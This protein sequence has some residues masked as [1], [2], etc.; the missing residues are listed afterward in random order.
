MKFRVVFCIH[1][2][3]TMRIACHTYPRTRYVRNMV[4]AR[5]STS[6]TNMM[7]SLV[8]GRAIV[9]ESS[10]MSNETLLLHL[11]HMAPMRKTSILLPSPFGASGSLK[12]NLLC[13]E[14][15]APHLHLATMFSCT[16]TRVH[17]TLVPWTT[18]SNTGQL[19]H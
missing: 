16:L 19:P 5:Y 3:T 2:P 7:D 15:M 9:H 17:Q 18:A 14:T 13:V 4:A 1:K 6:N 10:S 8:L 11:K 12:L